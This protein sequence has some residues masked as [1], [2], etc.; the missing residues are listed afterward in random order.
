MNSIRNWGEFF[1]EVFKV[2][3]SD[4][5]RSTRL[6]VL[7]LI[8]SDLAEKLFSVKFGVPL[9]LI[10]FFL[11]RGPNTVHKRLDLNFTGR[12]VAPEAIHFVL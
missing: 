1:L 10:S 4:G 6:F 2:T 5:M 11:V 7:F 8:C 12:K 9:S 3:C